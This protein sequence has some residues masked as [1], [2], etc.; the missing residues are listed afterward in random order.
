MSVTSIKK[1]NII[2][3]QKFERKTNLKSESIVDAIVLA[4][5]DHSVET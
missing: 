5:C 1:M 2:K 3:S 4:F